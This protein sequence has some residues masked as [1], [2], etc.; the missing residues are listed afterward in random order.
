MSLQYTCTAF[1]VS[2]VHH[3]TAHTRGRENVFIG[4]VIIYFMEKAGKYLSKK[5]KTNA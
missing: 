3:H 5:W 2:H 4:N 1:S